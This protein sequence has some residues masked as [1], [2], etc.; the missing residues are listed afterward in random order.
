MT[1]SFHHD[2]IMILDEHE[3]PDLRLQCRRPDR[4]AGAE[5]R[6]A[7][8]SRLV[9]QVRGGRNVSPRITDAS[10]ADGATE[11]STERRYG[12]S[13]AAVVQYRRSWRARLGDGDHAVGRYGAAE[14]RVR[15]SWSRSSSSTPPIGSRPAATCCCPISASAAPAS[16]AAAAMRCIPIPAARSAPSLWTPRR[17]G[18]LLMKNVLPLVL[19]GL[20]ISMIIVSALRPP[21]HLRLPRDRGQGSQG[22]SISPITIASPAC[23]TGACSSPSSS[24]S[25]KRP[26]RAAN[27]SPSPASTSTASRTST[28]RSATT[29]ATS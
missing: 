27:G 25:P 22:R 26:R 8:V 20:V 17:P 10:Y 21:A 1:E 29:P 5:E 15:A 9:A 2:R 14:R 7:A 18:L 24:P 13:A 19:V 3:P 4:D 23:P 6:L 16:S 11:G 28:T 12:R